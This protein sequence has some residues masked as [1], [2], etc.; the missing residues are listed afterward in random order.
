MQAA[1]RD[2]HSKA[3]SK[4]VKASATVTISEV[5]KF[6]KTVQHNGTVKKW[7]QKC[8]SKIFSPPKRKHCGSDHTL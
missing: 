1:H 5:A 8:S 2:Q 3:K 7:T 6:S 4:R